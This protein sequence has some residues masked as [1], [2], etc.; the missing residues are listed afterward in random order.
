MK[1]G[2]HFKTS[3]DIRSVDVGVQLKT[4]ADIRPVDVGVHRNGAHGRD[5]GTMGVIFDGFWVVKCAILAL[6]R[7]AAPM[8][9]AARGAAMMR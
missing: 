6:F 1:V 4:G 5:L 2:V 9:G 7:G 3:A 8:M